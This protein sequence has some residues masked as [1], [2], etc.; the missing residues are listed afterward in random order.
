MKGMS[1]DEADTLGREL[2]ARVGLSEKAD[3][4]PNQLSGGQQQRVAIAVL[5]P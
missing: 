3:S 5:W 1:K 4:H 2:L